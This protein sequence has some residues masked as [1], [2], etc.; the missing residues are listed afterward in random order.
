MVELA[1]TYCPQ[2]AGSSTTDGFIF[3]HKDGTL[4]LRFYHIVQDS[5]KEFRVRMVFFDRSIADE[6]LFRTH[7]NI[8]D[9][10]ETERKISETLAYA[11]GQRFQDSKRGDATAVT[12]V[13]LIKEFSHAL[14]VQ[15]DEGSRTRMA[16]ISEFLKHLP[17]HRTLIDG[18]IDQGEV[19]ML[20]APSGKGASTFLMNL[21]FCAWTGTTFLDDFKIPEPLRVGY[22]QY[23]G[24]PWE[25]L[26]RFKRLSQAFPGFDYEQ[27]PF[28]REYERKLSDP[29]AEATWRN[30]IEDN[31]LDILIPDDFSSFRGNYDE[32]SSNDTKEVVNRMSNAAVATG[33]AI[34]FPHHVGKETEDKRT[35]RIYY[36]LTPRGS[37]EIEGKCD[38]SFRFVPDPERPRELRLLDSHK[39]RSSSR[40]EVHKVLTYDEGTMLVREASILDRRDLLEPEPEEAPFQ[41]PKDITRLRE[42]M[43]LTQGQLAE[44]IGAGVRSVNGWEAGRSSPQ[45]KYR[46]RLEALRRLF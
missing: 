34:I 9:D 39:V 19:V 8:S 3:K 38:G 23:E 1:A 27:I 36:P 14:H 6:A 41:D 43:G 4:E 35:G 29:D 25:T 15:A 28:H 7:A 22:V 31:D 45:A 37:T 24:S 12:F 13:Q 44:R 21:M 5:F 20:Y 16:G 10:Y 42:Q 40:G 17:E 18:L 30:L 32:N 11:I 46:A 26:D 2:W 33:S